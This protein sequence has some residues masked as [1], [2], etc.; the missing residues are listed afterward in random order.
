MERAMRPLRQALRGRPQRATAAEP[1][2]DGGMAK[3]S[4]APPV[5]A[6]LPDVATG[7]LDLRRFHAE[8]LD[9]LAELFAQVEVWRYPHGRGFTRDET[10][11]FLDSQMREWTDLGFGCWVARRVDDG[12]IIG[13]VGLSVPRFLPEILPAVEVG[14][15][16]TPSV[17]GAGYATEGAT[18]A[19]DEAFE[20]LELTSV[21]SLMQ[22]DNPP[23]A[24]VAERL[25][26]KLLGEVTIP[27]N[28]RRGELNV[29][30][31]VIERDDWLT[32]DER[33]RPAART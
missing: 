21:C 1:C 8:D 23:S 17:W 16:F 10:S 24:R 14:W 20:T 29:L 19:L 4:L 31:Y 22:V 32:R 15:R 18:A 27:A 13:Y 12:R 33:P 9:E 5:A 2:E 11:A 6:P 3:S 25:G 7:R 28:D 26:M 30:H